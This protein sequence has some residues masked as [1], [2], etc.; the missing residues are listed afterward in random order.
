MLY[1]YKHISAKKKNKYRGHLA[2]FEYLWGIARCFP[3]STTI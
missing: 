1:K 2:K 3:T